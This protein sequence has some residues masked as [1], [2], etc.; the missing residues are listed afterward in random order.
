M[1]HLYNGILYSKWI[2]HNKDSFHILEQF[3]GKLLRE[4]SKMHD[5]VYSMLPFI[6]KYICKYRLPLKEYIINWACSCLLEIEKGD[7][8]TKESCTI[9]SCTLNFL[10]IHV[11]IINKY[12]NMKEWC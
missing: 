8:A 11:L 2:K 12:F 7:H 4:N 3:P 6:L 1:V 10:H 5:H 9:Y